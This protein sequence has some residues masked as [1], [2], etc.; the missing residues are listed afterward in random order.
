VIPLDHRS[1]Q[2]AIADQRPVVFDNS[3]RAGRALVRLAE[4]M[5][6]G[7]LHLPMQASRYE[8][9]PWWRRLFGRQPTPGVSRALARVEQR[10][11]TAVAGSRSRGW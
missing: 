10:R 1:M 8:R 9:G 4:G 7:K 3:S 5:H 2:R 6:T 11:V